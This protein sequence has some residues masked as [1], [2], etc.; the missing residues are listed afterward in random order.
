MANQWFKFYGAEYLSD[1]KILQL[2][3]NERSC[4]TTLMALASQT[5]DGIIKFLSEKQL[6]IL[7]GVQEDIKIFEKLEKLKMITLSNGS[8]TL[9]NWQKRQL[10][11]GYFRVKKFR[12][13][14]CNAKDNDRIEENRIEENRIDKNK[15]ETLPDW[16]DKQVWEEWV[17]Y[18]KEKKKP[19]T[20]RSIKLQLDDLAE[21]KSDHK[22]IIRNSIKNGWTGLFPLKTKRIIRK[23]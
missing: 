18:R 13:K 4:W 20:A 7:S 21:N 5:E 10:S 8:V 11:E 15:Q 12:E 16:L 6:L 2:N 14:N 17:A 9:L 19:L 23:I 22:Q 3:G 1:P